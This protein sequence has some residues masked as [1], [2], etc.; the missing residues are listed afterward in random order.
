MLRATIKRIKRIWTKVPEVHCTG[1]CY[2]ACTNVPVLPAEAEYIE[3]K[4]KVQLPML[5]THLGWILKTLGPA[6]EPCRF[7]ANHRCSIY[8]DR[9]L[10]CRTFGHNINPLMCPHGCTVARELPVS[11][12]QGLVREL[13]N[14]NGT[15]TI[16]AVIPTTQSA[17]IP[18]TVRDR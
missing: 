14:V 18:G 12:F 16:P 2:Q 15:V 7:L 9:P 17:P 5:P 6:S 3:Q 1:A 13:I 11:M 4:Y 8:E 10:V